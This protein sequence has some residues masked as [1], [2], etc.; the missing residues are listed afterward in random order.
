M[1]TNDQ[2][3]ERQQPD[4]SAISA[5]SLIGLG[6]ARLDWVGLGCAGLGLAVL[7][8][9]GLGCAGLCWAGLGWTGLCCARLGW[10]ELSKNNYIHM[11]L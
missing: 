8:W 3:N 4:S 9:A 1:T 7:G 10:A 11:G 5:S 6:W 2:M